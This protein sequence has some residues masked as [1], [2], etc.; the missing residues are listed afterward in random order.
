MTQFVCWEC[1]DATSFSNRWLSS[2]VKQTLCT[3]ALPGGKH[4]TTACL[5]PLQT[6]TSQRLPAFALGLNSARPTWIVC[7][8]LAFVLLLHPLYTWESHGEVWDSTVLLSNL[9]VIAFVLMP[10][11]TLLL[12]ILNIFQLRPVHFSGILSLILLI[13]AQCFTSAPW[14]SMPDP[15]YKEGVCLTP[16]VFHFPVSP[17]TQD[18]QGAV[19]AE[20]ATADED[21]GQVQDQLRYIRLRPAGTCGHA[22]K[23]SWDRSHLNTPHLDCCHRCTLWVTML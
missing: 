7:F 13:L 16:H 4:L 8:S 23:G 2:R 20:A 14:Q 22:P 10:R 11:I 19:V 15:I 6:N 21:P 18:S 9:C 12:F 5:A 3:Y 17:Q 1:G